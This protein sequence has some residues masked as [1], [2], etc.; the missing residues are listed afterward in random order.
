MKVTILGCGP[1]AG[2]PRVGDDW[3]MVNPTNPKNRRSR[4]SVMVEASG[5]KILVDTGPDLREQLLAN[6]IGHVDAVIWT[7]D[8]A[9]HCHGLDDIRAICMASGGPVAGYARTYTLHELERRFTYAFKGKKI[10]SAL[11][12]AK[13]LDDEQTISGIKVGAVDMPHGEISSAGLRFE[14]GGY[15]IGY[16]TDFNPVTDEMTALF[17]GID[18]LVVDAMR[19]RPHPLHPTLDMILAWTAIIK[20]RLTVLTHMD[21]TM[22]YD[23]LTADLPARVIPAYDGMQVDLTTLR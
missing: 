5:R 13:L 8:H 23:Q 1:S 3:G 9:D 22:D 21:S 10:Y 18:V 2:V 20:P 11:Y 16:A 4:A 19:R 14:H 6:N 17:D 12:D 15:S 7:H